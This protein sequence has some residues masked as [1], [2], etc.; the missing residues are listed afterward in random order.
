MLREQ[1]CS[2][3]AL[4]KASLSALHRKGLGKTP[5]LD[6]KASATLNEEFQTAQHPFFPERDR[7]IPPRFPKVQ[8]NCVFV[9][10]LLV[11]LPA[12]VDP[13]SIDEPCRKQRLQALD[14]PDMLVNTRIV[15]AFGPPV[16]GFRHILL[17][18][19]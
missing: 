16:N 17:V 14:G 6:C 4:V 2:I 19:V 11:T 18:G 1:A 9:N 5:L 15:T 8:K 7:E 12:S 13:A 10:F 3:Q